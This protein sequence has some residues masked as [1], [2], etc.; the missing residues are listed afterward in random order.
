MSHVQSVGRDVAGNARS[1]NVVGAA[2][3][4]IGGV[5]SIPIHAAVGTAATAVSLPGIAVSAAVKTPQT[6]RARAAAYLVV[7]N[8]DWLAA[9]GLHAE[10]MD[11]KELSQLVGASVTSVADAV[12]GSA[13]KQ[14]PNAEAAI[15]LKG[16]EDYIA[17]L[18]LE[19]E[20]VT[21]E[22]GDAT[23]WLVL[24]HRSAEEANGTQASGKKA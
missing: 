9:R 3:K 15:Q 21:L 6:P 1:G 13:K 22:L 11:S 4:L 20:G 14:G 8:Q 2:F 23:L 16:L 5:I 10:L 19:G 18:Q 12:K 24:R 7:A 17:E